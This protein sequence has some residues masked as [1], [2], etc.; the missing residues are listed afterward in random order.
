MNC[1]NCGKQ[2]SDDS[3]FCASCGGKLSLI[4]NQIE[5]QGFVKPVEQEKIRTKKKANPVLVII[6]VLLISSIIYFTNG[7]AP[8]KMNY[9]K[10]NFVNKEQDVFVWPNQ[11]LAELL[12]EPSTNVGKIIVDNESCFQIDLTNYSRSNFDK[13][14]ELCKQKGFSYKASIESDK[15]FACDKD[16]NNLSLSFDGLDR[17]TIKLETPF[18]LLELEWPV[19]GS[20]LF[21]PMP[22]FALGHIMQDDAKCFHAYVSEL[23]EAQY[24]EY[25]SK[26][27]KNNFD[28]KCEESIN[29]FEGHDLLGNKLTLEYDSEFKI[30]EIIINT[31]KDYSGITSET[32]PTRNNITFSVDCIGNLFFSKYDVEVYVDNKK[33]GKIPHGKAMTKTTPLMS[34]KH[35]VCFKN[36]KDGTVKNETYINVNHKAT[37]KYTIS[38]SSDKISVKETKPIFAPFGSKELD[39]KTGGK[40]Q[41]AFKEAGFKNVKVS[42]IYD[43]SMEEASK[44]ASVEEISIDG[45][46][47]FTVEDTFFSDSPVVIKYHTFKMTNPPISSKDASSYNYEDLVSKFKEVGFSNITVEEYTTSYGTDNSVYTISI[48]EKTSFTNS[49]KFRIDS[50]IIIKYRKVVETP[51]TVSTTTAPNYG[52]IGG[53][54]GGDVA[55]VAAGAVASNG[56]GTSGYNSSVTTAPSYQASGGMVWI[57]E[58]GDKYHSRSGCSGMKNPY[59][60]PLEQAVASGREACKKCY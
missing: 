42:A 53:T 8:T 28:Q 50:A 56:G 49:D 54:T 10:S 23:D 57:T 33:I 52:V 3:K 19:K 48:D 12:P 43:L 36:A 44:K 22:E 60:V 32:K 2:N 7:A 41:T 17:M 20:S 1:P 27:K 40:T 55:G 5:E 46:T 29:K 16:R 4:D 9:Y 31:V 21:I 37:V 38:C 30:L 47:T 45:K 18:S 25:V 14:V 58:S 34:G 15:Y 51:T 13:Y 24:K 59:Q 35:S 11:G 6:G 39:G 26:C